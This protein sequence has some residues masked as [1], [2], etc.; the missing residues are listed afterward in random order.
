MILTIHRGDRV[1]LMHAG[2]E[3]REDDEAVVA[4]HLEEEAEALEALGTLGWELVP[5]QESI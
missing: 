2:L 3:V 1:L 4:L 5:G